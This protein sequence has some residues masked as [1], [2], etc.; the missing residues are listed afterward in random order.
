MNNLKYYRFIL[1]PSPRKILCPNCNQK[2]FVGM[3]DQE[4]GEFISEFG[5]CDREVKCGYFLF[6]DQQSRNLFIISPKSLKT[7][8]KE[9]TFHDFTTL[10]NSLDL[11]NNLLQY[12][13]I[14]F[15]E[16]QK[17]KIQQTYFIGTAKDFNNGTIFW[18]VDEKNRIRGG[19]IICYDHCGRRT[20]NINWVH[21]LMKTKGKLSEFNLKQCLFGLHLISGDVLSTIAI[22]ESEKTACIMSVIFPQFLWMACGS[23]TEFKYEKLLPLKNRKIIA[24]PDCEIHADNSTTFDEWNL[25]ASELNKQGFN[26]TVSNLLEYQ[27][28]QDQK[29]QGVDI[30]D[31]FMK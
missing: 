18:Q 31:F 12:L 20:K 23:K 13:K 21:N 10:K 27:A 26:I 30:A 3:I 25:K 14:L 15:G 7:E 24:Y 5:R 16:F 1:D 29:I 28:T 9:P 2:T 22:V 19:K 4:T 11:E 8:T 6:P 17:N